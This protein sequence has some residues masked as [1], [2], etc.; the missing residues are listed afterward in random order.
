MGGPLAS[1]PKRLQ[2][3]AVSEVPGPT[4]G[5]VPALASQTQFPKP[6]TRPGQHRPQGVVSLDVVHILTVN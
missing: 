3:R 5:T 4:T 6:H 1:L 2:S